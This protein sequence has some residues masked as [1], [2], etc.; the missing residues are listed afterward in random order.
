M[1]PTD[2]TISL[3]SPRFRCPEAVIWAIWRDTRMFAYSFSLSASRLRWHLHEVYVNIHGVT[4]YLLRTVET[5]A[6]R[7]KRR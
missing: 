7:R 4:H 5:L 6:G 2:Q 3:F 1:T